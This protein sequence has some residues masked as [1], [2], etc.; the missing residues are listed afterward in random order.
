MQ[1]QGDL[2]LIPAHW[3]HQTYAPQ[4]SL[5]V[6]SQRCGSWEARRVL[7]HILA[8]QPQDDNLQ[9][10]KWRRVQDESGYQ[11]Q[12]AKSTVQLLF[13]YLQGGNGKV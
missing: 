4:P 10:E 11:D 7:D 8:L 2:L 5:A 13:D 1:T 9:K 12:D 3:Y 6:A